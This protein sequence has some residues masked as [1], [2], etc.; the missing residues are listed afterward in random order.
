MNIIPA[1][2]SAVAGMASI[3]IDLPK[4]GTAR[5]NGIRING[6]AARRHDGKA[7][8]AGLRSELIMVQTGQSANT[9]AVEIDV[10][11]PTRPDT[12]AIFT[13]AVGKV[14]A[15]LAP[16]S[17]LAG[18]KATLTVNT[19]KVLLFDPHNESRIN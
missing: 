8:L 15:R 1:T 10:V 12:L 4:G 6:E 7:V 3:T 19:E 16:K 17:E 11:E 14:V 18:Q 2:L 13:L 5:L 9:I